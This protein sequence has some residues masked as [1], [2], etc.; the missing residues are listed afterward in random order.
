MPEVEHGNPRV[1]QCGRR[2]AHAGQL[3]HVASR[4]ALVLC[5]ICAAVQPA[6]A[7]K[8]FCALTVDIAAADGRTI[9]STAVELIDPNGKV[10]FQTIS[11]PTLQICDFGFGRHRLRVG[12]NERYPV[13]AENVRLVMSQPLH[14]K[15]FLPEGGAACGGRIFCP[16]YLRVKDDQGAPIRDVTVTSSKGPEID[17]TDA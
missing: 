5:L 11:G 1:I 3:E 6:R 7:G 9:R 16:V 15:V 2:R 8:D 14:L 12:A 4:A 13:V 17:T 10:V